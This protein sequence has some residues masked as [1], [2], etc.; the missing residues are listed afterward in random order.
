MGFVHA[1]LITSQ[2][3]IFVSWFGFSS[4]GQG[5]Q[6]GAEGAA[7]HGS[8]GGG[9]SSS[10]HAPPFPLPVSRQQLL[11]RGSEHKN[12]GASFTA[13]DDLQCEAPVVLSF[14]IFLFL[15]FN[16]GVSNSM[17]YNKEMSI[18]GT[19]EEELEHLFALCWHCWYKLEAAGQ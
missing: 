18:H 2:G 14:F 9:L 10:R 5:K 3:S 11:A 8:N 13:L 15:F 1:Q 6:H 12:V 7:S 4:K 19:E 17:E 16:F